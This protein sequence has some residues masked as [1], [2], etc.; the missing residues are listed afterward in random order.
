MR[1]EILTGGEIDNKYKD[2]A[3]ELKQEFINHMIPYWQG[4]TDNGFGGFYGVMNQDLSLD[5]KADKGGIL[6]SRILW[7]FSNAYTKFRDES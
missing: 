2:I 6:N 1:T 4:L 5:K 7:F 3:E